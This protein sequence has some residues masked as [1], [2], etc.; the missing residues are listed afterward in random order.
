[1]EKIVTMHQ[2]NYLPWIGLFSKISLADCLVIYDTAQYE[3]NGVVNRNRIRTDRGS[4]YLTIPLGNLPVETRISDV[5][6][7]TGNEWRQQHW[8]RIRENYAKTPFFSDYEDFFENLYLERFLFLRELNER[9]LMYLL[10]CFNIDVEIIRTSDIEVDP[11]LR[12]TD[13]MIA[14]LKKADARIYLSGPSGK[15]Y[16]EMD[17]FPGNGID[18]TFFKFEHPSYPQRYAGFE[19]N[20]SAIDLLFNVGP[21][22]CD[23]IKRAA[24]M[25]RADSQPLRQ[26]AQE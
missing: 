18:L 10:S 9:I 17:K 3:K 7:P 26:A 24:S 16:L 15:N 23:V 20:M 8:R 13:L 25:E 19:S 5:V 12:K 1:M 11:D 2:P 4:T 6:L 14:Y 21:N 22:S